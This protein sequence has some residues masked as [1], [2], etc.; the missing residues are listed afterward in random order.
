V[1]KNENGIIFR[2][3]GGKF[4][5]HPIFQISWRHHLDKNE[6]H[7]VLS[8]IMRNFATIFSILLL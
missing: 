4:E 8:K 3:A 7:L 1:A 2:Q 6:K 5:I